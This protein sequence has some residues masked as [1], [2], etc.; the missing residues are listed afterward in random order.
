MKMR[1]LVLLLPI[2]ALLAAVAC[3]KKK[4]P[5]SPEPPVAEVVADAGPD[6]QEDTAPPPTLYDRLGGADGVKQVVD[7]L[8]E[9]V[10]SDPAVNKSFR[11]TKGPKLEALKKSIADQICEIAGGPCKYGGK[12]MK[13][14]HKGMKIT[15][16]QFESFVNDLKLALAEA[17]VGDAEQAEL[18]EKL[19]PLKED[20]VE[21]KPKKK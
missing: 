10:T 19:A 13:T 7:K 2:V 1:F 18:L 17:K 4:P 9:N 16:A 5:A 15:E 14:A 3:G 20:V 8:V 11:N 21:A 6:V 12:D